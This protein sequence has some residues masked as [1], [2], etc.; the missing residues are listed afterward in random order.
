MQ[1]QERLGSNIAFSHPNSHPKKKETN[2][3][4]GLTQSLTTP[5]NAGPPP[6]QL[7]KQS[8]SPEK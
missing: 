3:I 5:E 7:V 8:V 4:A 1:R 6:L 2:T